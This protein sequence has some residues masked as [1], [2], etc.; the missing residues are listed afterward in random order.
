MA[1]RSF[2]L[3]TRF[4]QF[5][6]ELGQ[7]W[8]AFRAPETPMHLKALMLLVPLYLLSPVDLIPD[9]V[10]LVGWLDDLVVIPMLVSWIVSMLPRPAPVHP[11]G[12]AGDKTIDGTW[13]RL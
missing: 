13:R 6:T 5:R 12:R 7:L 4:L 9:F 10:P 2:T 11:R 8:R 3:L 1:N